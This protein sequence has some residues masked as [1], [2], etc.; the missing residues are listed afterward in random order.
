M[1]GREA[2][3]WR[4]SWRAAEFR[5]LREVIGGSEPGRMARRRVSRHE[6]SIDEIGVVMNARGVSVPD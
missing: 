6:G 5:G 1:E 3:E 2:P 4:A